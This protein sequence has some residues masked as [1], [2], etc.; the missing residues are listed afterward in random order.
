MKVDELV[1]CSNS[2]H[3]QAEALLEISGEQVGVQGS[4]GL[5]WRVGMEVSDRWFQEASRSIN[6]R[7]RLWE[8]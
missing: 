3:L 8:H 4:A 1:S 5:L 2:E 6:S 7:L